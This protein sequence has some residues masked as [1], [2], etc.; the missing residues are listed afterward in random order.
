MI[1]AIVYW[2]NLL[3][4]LRQMLHLDGKQMIC[5]KPNL[6][7]KPLPCHFDELS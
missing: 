1:R 5:M 3:A 6:V 4:D 2:L 7:E